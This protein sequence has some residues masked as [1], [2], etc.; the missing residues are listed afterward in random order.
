MG[1]FTWM[2]F[3]VNV[4]FL[5]FKNCNPSC[6]TP[7][8]LFHSEKSSQSTCPAIQRPIKYFLK[9]SGGVTQR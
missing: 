9:S 4:P 3:Q 8:P 1:T 6:I 2:L 5:F 7:Y